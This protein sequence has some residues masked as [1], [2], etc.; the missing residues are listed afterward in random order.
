M[1]VSAI[2]W[3]RLILR[4]GLLLS[5][6]VVLLLLSVF[7]VGGDAGATAGYLSAELVLPALGLVLLG[8][9]LSVRKT[10]LRWLLIIPG[11]LFLMIAVASLAGR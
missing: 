5:M 6:V 7:V 3:P 2:N 10:W 1:D 11:G 4:V 9:G 8:G